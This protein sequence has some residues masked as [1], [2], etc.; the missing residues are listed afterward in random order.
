MRERCARRRALTTR[1][2]EVLSELAIDV[3]STPKAVLNE[4]GWRAVRSLIDVGRGV[5]HAMTRARLSLLPSAPAPATQQLEPLPGE[6]SLDA[7]WQCLPAATLCDEHMRGWESA[8]QQLGVLAAQR[9]CATETLCERAH[10]V[11]VDAGLVARADIVAL[12]TGMGWD[13]LCEAVGEQL[14]AGSVLL[15]AEHDAAA[16]TSG[17]DSVLAVA[18]VLPRCPFGYDLLDTAVAAIVNGGGTLMDTDALWHLMVR[19][20]SAGSD[21]GGAM[22]AVM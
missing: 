18:S 20:C 12:V 8:V 22:L 10:A 7:E 5:G 16:G 19:G 15:L 2:R 11:V 4:A 1:A 17:A 14:N 9:R 3:S 13:R 6:A 21:G